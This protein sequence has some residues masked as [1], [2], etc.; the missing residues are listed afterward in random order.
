[1]ATD[2]TSRGTVRC[3]VEW[4]TEQDLRLQMQSHTFSQLLMLIESAPE[5][6][7]LF[8]LP[9]MNPRV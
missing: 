5:P 8:A 3:T 2:L 4:L 9:D 1:M 6:R 7:I